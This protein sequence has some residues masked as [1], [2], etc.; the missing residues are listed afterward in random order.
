MQRGTPTS[1]T[2]S[3]LVET[4]SVLIKQGQRSSREGQRSSHPGRGDIS[5]GT[6]RSHG[7]ARS[8]KEEGKR[9]ITGLP[10]SPWCNGDN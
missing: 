10:A 7:G 3:V 5:R 9:K 1:T 4:G 8:K 6:G 2:R